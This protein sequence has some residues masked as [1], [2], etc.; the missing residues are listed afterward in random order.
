MGAVLGARLDDV[1]AKRPAGEGKGISPAKHIL[2]G[3]AVHFRRAP[4]P[5][6]E[7][8]AGAI[9]IA[10]AQK[11]DSRET[12]RRYVG[13]RGRQNDLE[14]SQRGML[15]AAVHDGGAGDRCEPHGAGAVG[16]LR[17]GRG[18]LRLRRSCRQQEAR[19]RGRRE[20]R[21]PGEGGGDYIE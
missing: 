9:C 11:F 1:L 18:E 20:G 12:P 14:A 19:R 10:R 4:L 17:R 5:I 8:G 3:I 15:A 6:G 21:Q 7:L 16:A 2:P 13:V